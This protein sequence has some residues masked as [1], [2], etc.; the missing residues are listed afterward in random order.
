[1]KRMVQIGLIGDHDPAVTAHRAI[2]D[3]LRLA[4]VAADVTVDFTWLPTDQ[5]HE[6]EQLKSFDGLWA[7]P[8]TPYRSMTGALRAIRHA[9]ER[10]IP[11]LGTCGGFQHA[12]IEYARNVLQWA[13]ADNAETAP[14]APRAVIAPLSCALVEKTGS[15][16]LRPGTRVA[17]AY[18][19]DRTTEGYHCRYGLNPRFTEALLSGPLRIAGV[20]DEGDVR[21]VE[22]D[23]HP[24]YVG[25]LFQPERSALSGKTPPIVSEFVRCSAQ[26]G[27]TGPTER[28]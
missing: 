27:R 6:T 26:A 2:P 25:T 1:M 9:R 5:I 28:T 14:D 8:S 13:D 23:G 18:G 21:A 22:L 3:A 10:Q 19:S 17:L 24:F 11:F 20:D 7:V 16:L 4:A 12:I 15:V